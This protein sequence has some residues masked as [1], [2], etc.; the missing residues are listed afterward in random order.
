MSVFGV[1]CCDV[2]L[3]IRFW[4]VKRKCKSEFTR[5]IKRLKYRNIL[6]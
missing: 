4:A 5:T 2:R 6:S 1:P 3:V